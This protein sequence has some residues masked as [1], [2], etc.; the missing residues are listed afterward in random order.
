MAEPSSPRSAPQ[1]FRPGARAPGPPTR[2]PALLDGRPPVVATARST[3]RGPEPPDPTPPAHVS[4]IA[5]RPS[6]PFAP[7][8]PR[9]TVPREPQFPGTPLASFSYVGGG[10]QQ[11][12]ASHSRPDPCQCQDRQEVTFARSSVRAKGHLLAIPTNPAKARGSAVLSAR[13]ATFWRSPATRQELPG[14][15]CLTSQSTSFRRQYALT[16]PGLSSPV[17]PSANPAFAYCSRRAPSL[18]G[19]PG[20]GPRASAGDHCE[21]L[22]G[23]CHQTARTARTLL[24]R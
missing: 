5:D 16:S 17:C 14:N 21:Q 8:A 3:T 11:P 12:Q 4:P 15:P 9:P 10:P 19:T 7:P 20:S 24:P 1:R 2:W 22:A 18:A 6:D 23:P 13:R